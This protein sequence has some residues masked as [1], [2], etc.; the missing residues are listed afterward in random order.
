MINTNAKR[1]TKHCESVFRPKASSQGREVFLLLRKEGGGVHIEG[2]SYEGLR[3]FV[4]YLWSAAKFMNTE[5]Y[6]E[7]NLSIKARKRLELILQKEIQFI[8]QVG[9]CH[10]LPICRKQKCIWNIAD[11]PSSQLA[12]SKRCCIFIILMYGKED[13]CDLENIGI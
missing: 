5:A 10:E 9:S 11:E 8:L 1:I 13:Q 3:M 6:A 2:R 7:K 4:K 12:I